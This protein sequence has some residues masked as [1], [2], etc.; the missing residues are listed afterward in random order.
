MRF[1]I[2]DDSRAVQNIIKRSLESAGYREIELRTALNGTEAMAALESWRPDL[3]LTDWHMPGMTGL[4]LLQSIRQM[5]MHDLK[6]GFVTTESSAR[7]IE[8][9]LRNGAAFV[10]NKPFTHEVLKQ[11]V[12]SVL[13]DGT[14]VIQAVEN[15]KIAASE[16]PA[17]K[18]VSAT[19]IQQLLALSSITCKVES[20]EPIP[21]DR[22]KTPYVLGIYSSQQSKTIDA[23]C[24]MDLNASCMIGGALASFPSTKIK[25][26]IAAMTLDREIYE[27]TAALINDLTGMISKASNKTLKLTSTHVVQK[28]FGKLYEMMQHSYGRS[29]FSVSFPG[30]GDG[31]IT[32]LVN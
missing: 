32:I 1:L 17:R 3:M 5:G 20:V 28:P 8:E 25:D 19:D 26:A 29:D 15:V 16:T 2:V 7:H 12:L 22:I 4:E 6:V 31:F 13:Q 18:E 23:I 9:A 14:D 27:N 24:L 21:I 10:V 30:H 11:A